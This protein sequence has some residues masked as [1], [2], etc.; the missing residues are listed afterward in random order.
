MSMP[1][2]APESLPT[3]ATDGAAALAFVNRPAGL[4]A[5]LDWR[6]TVL[7]L[8]THLLFAALLFTLAYWMGK[9]PPLEP[10]AIEVT[11]APDPA[12]PPPPRAR[13]APQPP[14]PPPPLPRA[15]DASSLG[16]GA[17]RAAASNDTPSA[18]P[19]ER[20]VAPREDKPAPDAKPA[21]KPDEPAAAPEQPRLRAEPA[22]PAPA[23]EIEPAPMPAPAILSAPAARPE[24]R[25][26]PPPR[27]APPPSLALRSVPRPAPPPPA[28]TRPQQR[29][30]ES[31]APAPSPQGGSAQPSGP[32]GAV[33]DAYLDAVRNQVM[34]HRGLLGPYFASSTRSEV[35]VRLWIDRAGRVPRHDFVVSSLYPNLDYTI[36]KMLAQSVPF[37][38]PPG[39]LLTAGMVAVILIIPLPGKLED[40]R[41]AYP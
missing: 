25:P 23:P 21:D 37:P 8:L 1:L 5:H 26:A 35:R 27:A 33:Y 4:F 40:W 17:P 14:A 19:A 36:E 9:P 29:S 22:P 3:P 16:D 2:P 41:Q 7:S 13:P 12:P 32:E 6:A 11:L 20:A 15:S 39:D 28:E 31:A 24:T 34:L 10:P 38:P 30:S 18:E